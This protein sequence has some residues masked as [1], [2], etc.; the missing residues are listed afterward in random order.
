VRLVVVQAATL[1]GVGVMLGL[2]GAAVVARIVAS[3][4][5]GVGMSGIAVF[6]V[7]AGAMCVIALTATLVPARRAM[8]VDPVKALRSE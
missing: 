6:A 2:V 3:M 1:S 8:G 7:A 5:Y 4:L